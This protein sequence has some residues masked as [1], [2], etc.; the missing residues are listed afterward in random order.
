MGRA[1]S[2]RGV[3]PALSDI[4]RAPVPPRVGAASPWSDNARS[5]RLA[6]PCA[7]KVC[8]SCA[9]KCAS[10]VQEEHAHTCGRP[11]PGALERLPNLSRYVRCDNRQIGH[12]H[13]C[14]CHGRFPSLM[15]A[16]MGVT[17]VTRT[18]IWTVTRARDADNRISRHMRHGPHALTLRPR[19]PR[20]S[21][22]RCGVKPRA[23]RAGDAHRWALACSTSSV[24]CP[25]PWCRTEVRKPE[26]GLVVHAVDLR[27]VHAPQGR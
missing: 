24:P 8:E 1:S 23:S 14:P 19:K 2:A 22:R 6:S 15:P 25:A 20:P 11:A 7:R 3:A 13:I 26:K 10:R 21:R 9:R 12:G 17:H 18:R 5:R 4:G 16:G 27:F